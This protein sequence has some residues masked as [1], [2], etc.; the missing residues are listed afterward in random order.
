M[1]ENTYH[2]TSIHIVLQ[3]MPPI[4]T[5][6]IMKKVYNNSEKIKIAHQLYL[7]YQLLED[8]AIIEMLMLD[9][10]LKS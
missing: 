3:K 7:L 1:K 4:S 2:L 6:L 10:A 5:I 9:A 8:I